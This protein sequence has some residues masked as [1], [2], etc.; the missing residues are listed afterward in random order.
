[1]AVTLILS[2]TP[3]DDLFHKCLRVVVLSFI[4]TYYQLF[5]Y[6]DYPLRF[7]RLKVSSEK[8][9]KR[10]GF[11]FLFPSRGWKHSC[12]LNS[13]GTPI[14]FNFSSPHGDGN[15]CGVG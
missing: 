9:F 8:G 14:G 1:M 11:Q 3:S 15:F 6:L 2:L 13:V 10:V 5:A 7:R 4:E 12:T